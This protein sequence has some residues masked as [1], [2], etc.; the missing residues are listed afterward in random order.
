MAS[1]FIKEEA[2]D[3]G[4][5][6]KE[7]EFSAYDDQMSTTADSVDKNTVSLLKIIGYWQVI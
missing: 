7:E 6:I 2:M 1:V 3:D 4:R 5:I